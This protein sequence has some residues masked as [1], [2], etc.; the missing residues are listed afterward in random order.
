MAVKT[1]RYS[2][3]LSPCF[4][5]WFWQRLGGDFFGCHWIL[6]P[7]RSGGGRGVQ[8][9]R[10]RAGDVEEKCWVLRGKNL[11]GNGGMSLI[12]TVNHHPV[13]PFPNE[14][15]HEVYTLW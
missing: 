9:G 13:P 8:A 1:Y 10:A 7:G 3:H 12:L 4:F 14:V 6:K 15:Y 5:L 2:I 11:V